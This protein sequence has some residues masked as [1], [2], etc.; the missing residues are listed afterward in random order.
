MQII[1]Q[2][3]GARSYGQP[4]KSVSVVVL[5]SV[6][7]NHNQFLS[8]NNVEKHLGVLKTTSVVRFFKW[9]GLIKPNVVTTLKNPVS[10]KKIHIFFPLMILL[11]TPASYTP[12]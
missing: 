10:K 12:D 4:H 7:L 11:Q 5:L 1:W 9:A 2:F 8:D 3:W 6:N